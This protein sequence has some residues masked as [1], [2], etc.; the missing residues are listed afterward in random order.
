MMG[1]KKKQQRAHSATTGSP[2]RGE[3]AARALI[4][5]LVA[6]VPLALAVLL[7]GYLWIDYILL[8]ARM[9]RHALAAAVVACLLLRGAMALL[10]RW[11]FFHPGVEL[12]AALALS[13]ILFVFATVPLMGFVNCTRDPSPPREAVGTVTEKR[14]VRGRSTSW[15]VTLSSR[16]AALDGLRV[17]LDKALWEAVEKGDSIVFDDLRPGRLGYPWY[18]KP[19]RKGGGG[20]SNSREEKL[21]SPSIHAALMVSSNV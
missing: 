5:A 8:D 15:Y 13:F 14:A 2:S 1:R 11:R 20:N 6:G 10:P 16:D 3:A 21:S 18:T 4:I 9:H 19:P 12:I 7:L 17:R